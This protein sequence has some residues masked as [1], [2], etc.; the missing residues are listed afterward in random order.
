[1]PLAGARIVF[2]CERLYRE[3]LFEL[4]LRYA[5][6]TPSQR[7]YICSHHCVSLGHDSAGGSICDY[8]YFDLFCLSISEGGSLQLERVFPKPQTHTFHS[9]GI[10][11]HRA[12]DLYDVS[13]YHRERPL[14]FYP[15]PKRF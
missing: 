3:S 12:F 13:E 1:M 10:T 2:L 5:F 7:V 9:D 6:T 4:I 14:G 15:L 8:P 11:Y